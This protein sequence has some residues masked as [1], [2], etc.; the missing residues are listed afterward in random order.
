MK[1]DS[2]ETSDSPEV[3]VQEMEPKDNTKQSACPEL[4]PQDSEESLAEEEMD[5]E[6]EDEEEEKKP[7][8]RN[9]RI[10][11]GV[12]RLSRYVAATVKLQSNHRDIKK[13]MRP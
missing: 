4:V 11:K 10:S 9:E 13:G 12:E 3:E 6:S 5:D 7:L 2:H 8:H 1:T